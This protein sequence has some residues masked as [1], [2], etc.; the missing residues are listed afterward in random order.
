MHAKVMETGQF[1]DWSVLMKFFKKLPTGFTENYMFEHYDGSVVYKKLLSTNDSDA[2][3]HIFTPTMAES[4]KAILKDLF[5]LKADASIQDIISAPLRLPVTPERKLSATKVASI[6][7]KFPMIPSVYRGYYPGFEE[8]SAPV[9]T[10]EASTSSATSAT[11]SAKSGKSKA[12]PVGR[13][14]KVAEA[15][16]N[17]SVLKFLLPA[18]RT[19]SSTV[20]TPPPSSSTTDMTASTSG[21]DSTANGSNSMITAIASTSNTP[22]T[23]FSNVENEATITLQDLS[24][25]HNSNTLIDIE[26]RNEPPLAVLLSMTILNIHLMTILVVV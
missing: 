8:Q 9:Q 25:P 18:R 26:K 3:I 21:S 19:P 11:V 6:R 23:T 22:I 4:R 12:R 15:N 16:G 5:G 13:P 20:S 14:K 1:Y 7:N 2:S 24:R 17:Q 10:V